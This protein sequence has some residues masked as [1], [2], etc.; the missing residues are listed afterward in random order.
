M[1]TVIHSRFVA[2][3]READACSIGGAA[4]IYLLIG[5]L[6]YATFGNRV[7][8]NILDSYHGGLLISTC[9]VAISVL[10]LFSCT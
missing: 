8:S 4:I 10:V 1:N 5:L 2:H 6:G 7:G 9:R 3:R